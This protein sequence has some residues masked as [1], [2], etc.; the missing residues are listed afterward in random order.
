M[1]PSLL[2]ALDLT[3]GIA[4]SS[5]RGSLWHKEDAFKPLEQCLSALELAGTPDSSIAPVLLQASYY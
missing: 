2:K 1:L 3:N 4:L 5:A